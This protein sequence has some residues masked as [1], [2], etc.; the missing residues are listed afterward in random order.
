MYFYVILNKYSKFVIFLHSIDQVSYRALFVTM[1]FLYGPIDIGLGVHGL[2]EVDRN[3][4]QVL[5]FVSRYL[6]E[7]PSRGFTMYADSG[8]EMALESALDGTAVQTCTI[9]ARRVLHPAHYYVPLL[10]LYGPY[11]HS[12]VSGQPISPTVSDASMADSDHVTDQTR[13][14]LIS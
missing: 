4:V 6:R 2:R 5:Y 13:F 10:L 9:H 3:V 14:S 11:G 1:G 12:R 7:G 8:Q